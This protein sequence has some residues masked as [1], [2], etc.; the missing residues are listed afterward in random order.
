MAS[1][2]HA[3]PTAATIGP[4]DSDGSTCGSSGDAHGVSCRLRLGIEQSSRQPMCGAHSTR[5][6]PAAAAHLWPA[7]EQV[8]LA[9]LAHFA[10][11]HAPIAHGGPARRR[12]RHLQRV[13]H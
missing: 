2:A 12:R 1:I 11:R 5:I 9:L 6:A 13:V 3:T 7:L 8:V 4:L 10:A